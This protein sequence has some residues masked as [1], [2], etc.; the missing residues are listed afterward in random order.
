VLPFLAGERS[1]G[2]AAHATAA[3]VGLR[4]ATRPVEIL[5]AGLEAVA[6]RCAL[7]ADLLGDHAANATEIIAS[8]GALLASP[9]WSQIMADVLGRPVRTSA[10]AEATSRGVALLVLKALGAITGLDDL[11]A[12]TSETYYPDPD[13]HRR[14]REA[15]E[16]QQRLY[17]AL[18]KSR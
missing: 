6:Y 7:I 10:E 15:V 2:Y 12:S 5:R 16:R 1:P 3:I 14:Y 11:P 8:G 17:E 9:A 4:L 13:R 18:I